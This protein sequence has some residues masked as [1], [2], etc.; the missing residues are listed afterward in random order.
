ME[1]RSTTLVAAARK[2]PSPLLWLLGLL[3][4]AGLGW[5]GFWAFAAM[6]TG[7]ALEAWVAREKTFGRVWSCPNPK[8]GGYPFARSPA[9]RR[10]S[11]G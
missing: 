2:P 4:V 1:S 11:T 6:Q 8:I 3:V 9:H 5:S 7:Q 10:V